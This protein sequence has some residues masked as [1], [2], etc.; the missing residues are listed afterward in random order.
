[1]LRSKKNIEFLVGEGEGK[2]W[3]LCLLQGEKPNGINYLELSLRA[4]LVRGGEVWEICHNSRI[5][6]M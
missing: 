6:I 5:N 1:M 4:G 3:G 2:E